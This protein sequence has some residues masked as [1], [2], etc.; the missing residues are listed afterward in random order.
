MRRWLLLAVG[1]A[2]GQTITSKRQQAE[3]I[4][5][6]GRQHAGESR[7][8]DRVVNYANIQLSKIDSDSRFEH[9]ASR[10]REEEPRPS[11]RRASPSGCATST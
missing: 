8:D 1:Q 5:G 11:P 2:S 4:M 6:P 9:Q 7:A 3:A 10:G